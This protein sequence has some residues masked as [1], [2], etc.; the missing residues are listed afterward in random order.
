MQTAVLLQV[1]AFAAACLA[2]PVTTS[3]LTCHDVIIPVEV[4]ANNIALPPN[5]GF[6]DLTPAFVESAIAT[7]GTTLV[8][9]QY[10]IGA[11]YCEPTT[12][13]PS[14]QQ[15]LQ[16]LIHGITY[17]RNYW[18]GLAAPGTKSGQDEYSW[19]VYAAEQGYPTLSIDRLCNGVSSH[20]N[21]VTACQNP[22]EAE[23]IHAVISIARAGQLPGVSKTF[24]KIIVVGH[25]L[26]SLVAAVLTEQHPSDADALLL[27]GF[28]F[29][30]TL[31][32]S[33]V[34][35]AFLVPAA[36]ANPAAYGNLDLG[37]L[38]LTSA[39]AVQKFFYFGQFDPTIAAYD[40]A[41]RG[42]V[43]VGEAATYPVGQLPI[44]GYHGPVFVLDG[45]EDIPWC[46]T[47][48][49]GPILGQPG[50]C[51]AGYAQAVH[52]FFPAASVFDYSITPDTGHCLNLHLTAQQ[53]YAAAHQFLEQVGF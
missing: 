6:A 18:S 34:I 11:R 12:V 13:V 8:Q 50:N 7:F 45:N 33:G 40:F 19:I 17:T 24:D 1:A 30:V 15:T 42:T 39:S 32:V 47:N 31:G 44:P 23:T 21:G 29:H 22:L 9:G 51:S 49:V 5:L 38:L 26:G 27:T 14:R 35:P 25:S 43:T 37:Y 2:A 48:P 16:V 28:S 20:P 10:N 3:P 41:H 4:S 52:N 53:S 36:I 46:S